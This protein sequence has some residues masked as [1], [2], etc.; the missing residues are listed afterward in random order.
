MNLSE[1]PVAPVR[2]LYHVLLPRWDGGAV[3]IAGTVIEG[4]EV[5]ASRSSTS[6]ATRRG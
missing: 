6:P 3:K 5:A 2:W 1:L 4:D